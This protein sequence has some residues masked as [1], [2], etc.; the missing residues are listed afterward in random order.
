[1]ALP[2]HPNVLRYHS[3]IL[4]ADQLH[5][6]TEYIEA[7]SLSD[8]V[9]GIDG[10]FPR[11]HPVAAVLRWIA[12]LFDGLA[13]LHKANMMH[14]D[15]HG[16]NILILRDAVTGTPSLG[17]CALRIIDFGVAKVYDDGKLQARQESIDAG[18]WQYFSPE[19]RRGDD[20]DDRDDVWSA[21]CH[22]IELTSGRKISK[23]KDCGADGIDFALS[24][25]QV[26]EAIDDCGNSRCR[27]CVEAA[28]V[29]DQSRRPR[30]A[31]MR[32]MIRGQLLKFLPGC[33]R[34]SSS[35]DY[36]SSGASTG[37]S[38]GGRRLRQCR[39]ATVDSLFG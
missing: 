23:R 27:Q 39:A 32:D 37:P 22:L 4:Q 31:V 13:E 33:K 29:I 3:S 16:D 21:G 36:C 38:G 5:I 7:Y 17:P 30:A 20:F 18:C 24:P 8:L 28:L 15:L 11:N 26:A 12:Q 2:M 1:V 10:P 9:P 6:V 19:R 14:H 35:L 34:P 25:A